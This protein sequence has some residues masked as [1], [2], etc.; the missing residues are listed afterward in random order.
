[1]KKNRHIARKVLIGLLAF[2][3]LVFSYYYFSSKR[4]TV[5]HYTIEAPFSAPIR[6]VHLTDLHNA[7]FG[8]DNQNLITMVREQ[9]PDLIAMTGDMLNRD[10][11]DLTIV[12]TLISRLAEIAPVYFGY[13]NHETT[14]ESVWGPVL[15]EEFSAAGAIVLDNEYLD[16]T[17]NGNDLRIAGYMGYYWQPHMM[18]KDPEQQNAERA[19]YG[20]FQDTDRYKILL[21]HIP[22]QWVDWEYIDKC[23]VDLVFCGHY[24]GGVVRIPLLDRGLTAPYVGWFPPYTKGLYIGTATICVLSAGLGSE[25][26]IPRLNNPPEIVVVDILPQT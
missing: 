23:P 8:E 4:L 3:L 12:K 20:A 5:T 1:M 24:H 10:D 2:A 16:V 18:T 6:I 22:T 14:W 25:Y 13:G 11:P 9:S 26:F 17:V 19:F 21:N 7:E 15:H